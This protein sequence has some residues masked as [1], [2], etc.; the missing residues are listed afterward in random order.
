MVLTR[1]GFGHIVAQVN[2]GRFVP[3][4]MWRK[5]PM[6]PEPDETASAIGRRLTLVFT[7]LGPTF[8]KLGQLLSTR[9]DIIPG[10]VA[11]ELRKLQDEVPPFDTAEAMAV[12][13][14]ELGRP[15]S[16]CFASIDSAPFA[17]AS[18]G[19]VYHATLGDGSAVVVKV[20]RPGIE[21][22][23][24][25][26][27]QLM[28]WLAQSL[29]NFM[30]ELRIY[31]PTQLVAE[32]DEVLTRELD[33]INEASV[34]CRFAEALKDE[35]GVRIPAVHWECCGPRVLTLEELPG[36]NVEKLLAE[37]TA[38]SRFDRKLVARRIVDGHLKQVF[39]LGMF[40]ADPH[41]GNILVDP[42]AR[43]GLIDFGQVGTISDQLMTD[44]I[45][46]AY[47]SINGELDVVIDT[48]ADMSALG[49]ETDRRMLHR[50]LI[51]LRQKYHGLPLKRF[52]IG[53]IFT[54]FTDLM[55]RHDVVIPRDLSMLIKATSTISGVAA[56]LDPELDVL[57]LL[58]P[59]LHAAMRERFSPSHVTRRTALWSWD[60]LSIARNAPKQIRH[61]FRRAASG[62]ELH[63]RHEN[64]D[65]LIQ[66]VDR[67]SNRLS[68]AVVIAGI[69][70]GSSIVFSADTTLLFFGWFRVQYFGIAGYLLAGFLGLGLSWAIFRSGRLH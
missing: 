49:R 51:V 57:E 52:H 36:R 37:S 4:W 14:E 64:L 55:R 10:D 3:V 67:S 6:P 28:H 19:Q 58:R 26:D 54:E 63:V 29:E 65:R 60:L 40:H 39:E 66:E 68:F 61:F 41:P 35:R 50:A 48:L 20:R 8:I 53:T 44:L 46:L 12:I 24:R 22:T 70:V 45:A 17:S 1:H 21:Q 18:I 31:R 23:I 32:L 2:L 43:V 7:E 38:N 30:P 11:A 25:L 33:Y 56:S 42:P 69:I 27:M 47:A 13:E 15:A 5:K 62:W 59:R 16:E 9:P 34:T